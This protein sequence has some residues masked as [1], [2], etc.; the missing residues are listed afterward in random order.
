MQAKAIFSLFIS[1]CKVKKK[2]R[3]IVQSF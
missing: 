3:I 2:S 1:M